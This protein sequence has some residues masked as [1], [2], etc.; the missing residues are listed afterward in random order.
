MREAIGLWIERFDALAARERVMIFIALA[1]VL[2]YTAY[3]AFIQPLRTRE[4][5]VVA[6]VAQQKTDM[7]GLQ[8]QLQR[9][10]QGTSADPDASNRARAAALRDQLRSLNARIAQEQRRFTPPERMRG[11][12][13]ELLERHRGLALV[14][15]RTLPVV[16]VQGSRAGASGGGMYRHGIEISVRGSYGELYEYLRGLEKLPSQLY[17]ARAELGVERHPALTLKLTLHTLSFDR[18]WLIV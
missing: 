1:L 11:V 9:V 16:P 8:A 15:M 2:V 18:A 7:A 17:W 14:D 12:L 10:I 4:R 5:A 3:A 13:E 6:Q